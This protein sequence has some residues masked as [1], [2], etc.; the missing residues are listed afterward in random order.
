MITQS[1]DQLRKF[2]DFTGTL[3]FLSGKGSQAR[4]T[5]RI[6]SGVRIDTVF[7]DLYGDV[8][9][10]FDCDANAEASRARVDAMLEPSKDAEWTVM[11]GDEVPSRYVFSDLVSP[12][13]SSPTTCTHADD[14]SAGHL[15][16]FRKER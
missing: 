4:N 16:R 1:I 15:P 10:R 14:E 2:R 13:F 12:C 11:I 6:K 9:W 8:G 5:L 7:A 3:K